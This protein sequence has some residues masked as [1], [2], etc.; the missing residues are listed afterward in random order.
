[1]TYPFDIGQ[2]KC[3]NFPIGEKAFITQHVRNLF[4]AIQSY[5]ALMEE[6]DESDLKKLRDLHEA[7]IN[8]DKKSYQY[9]LS[10]CFCNVQSFLHDF[11]SVVKK[12]TDNLCDIVSM[13]V[14]DKEL[15]Q[16]FEAKVVK[17][18]RESPRKTYTMMFDKLYWYIDG[19]GVPLPTNEWDIIPRYF[20]ISFMMQ[21]EW[22]PLRPEDTIFDLIKIKRQDEVHFLKQEQ[23]MRELMQK[24]HKLVDAGDAVCEDA[25]CDTEAPPPPPAPLQQ[26]TQIFR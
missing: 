23:E 11:L 6:A 3:D 15:E 22:I 16:Y 5:Q 7:N 17:S 2:P 1:M 9:L 10:P 18:N 24:H 14:G 26:S 19:D 21:P 4:V 13:Y 12:H 8:A 25:V 20:W